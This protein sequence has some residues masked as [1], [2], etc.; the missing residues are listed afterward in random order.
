MK[1]FF[2]HEFSCA[3]IGLRLV[4][5]AEANIEDMDTESLP[6]PQNNEGV[7]QLDFSDEDIDLNNHS[8]IASV[9]EGKKTFKCTAEANIEYMETESLP[10]LQNNEEVHNEY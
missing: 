8:D 5:T 9:H 4:I 3:C 1:M 7:I 6:S 2:H 10:S